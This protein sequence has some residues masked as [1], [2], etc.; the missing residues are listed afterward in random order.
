MSASRPENVDDFGVR[1]RHGCHMPGW[2][3]SG[4]RVAGV[5][6][7]RCAGCGAVRLVASKKDDR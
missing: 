4:P 1:H 7:L 2:E 5:H 6:V 3:S